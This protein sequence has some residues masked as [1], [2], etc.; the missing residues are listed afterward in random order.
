M[1]RELFTSFARE[2][3]RPPRAPEDVTRVDLCEYLLSGEALVYYERLPKAPQPAPD[4][5]RFLEFPPEIRNMI[6]K[7]IFVSPE[8]IGSS[9]THGYEARF[10]YKKAAK[11][12]NLAFAMSCRQIFKESSNI[13]FTDNCFEF[14]QVYQVV[15]FMEKIGTEGQRQVK[16]LKL[17]YRQADPKKAFMS[18]RMCPNLTN[19]DIAIEQHS[20]SD[21]F[22]LCCVHYPIINAKELIFGDLEEITLGDKT[23]FGRCPSKRLRNQDPKTD[24]FFYSF[25]QG[26]EDFKRSVVWLEKKNAREAAKRAVRSPLNASCLL[27]AL[28]ISSLGKVVQEK[29]DSH[30]GPGAMNIRGL[31]PTPNVF[32]CFSSIGK[33]GLHFSRMRGDNTR[34]WLSTFSSTIHVLLAFYAFKGDIS[35]TEGGFHYRACFMA[36]TG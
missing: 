16:K 21:K 27:K 9:L 19:L 24:G 28:L 17:N 13:F 1:S 36:S 3:L 23:I 30:L 2:S 11:W 29:E 5:I 35:L 18:I 8:P 7:F 20:L 10:S 33:D 26:L 4:F 32:L 6:Y 22:E 25:V 12:R 14:F 31:C 34:S 15:T